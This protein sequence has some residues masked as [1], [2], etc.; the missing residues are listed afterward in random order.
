VARSDASTR[1]ANDAPP[2]DLL[3]L[4]GMD[5]DETRRKLAEAS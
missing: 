4:S 5:V 2:D 1:T 3:R